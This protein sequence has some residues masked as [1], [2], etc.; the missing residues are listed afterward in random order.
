M[1]L[2]IILIAIIRTDCIHAG[3]VRLINSN[4]IVQC[5]A[6]PDECSGIRVFQKTGQ[7]E[8]N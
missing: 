8:V 2:R 6:N 7:N 5:P 4:R 1:K 3:H